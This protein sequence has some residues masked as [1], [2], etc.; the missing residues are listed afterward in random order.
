[1]VAS[2]HVL[3]WLVKS[4]CD[5]SIEAPNVG[6]DAA[7]AAS[8]FVKRASKKFLHIWKMSRKMS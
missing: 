8:E 1:M 7:K 6:M 4:G 2:L 5:L 3:K